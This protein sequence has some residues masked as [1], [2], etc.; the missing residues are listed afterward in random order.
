MS[1]PSSDALIRWVRKQ[2][3]WRRIFIFLLLLAIVWIPL[4]GPLYL[5]GY[6]FNRS[7][8]AE[9]LALVLLYGGFL[10]GLPR[11]GRRVHGWQRPF[12]RCGLVL[13][14]QTL[15]DCVIALAIGVA[16]VFA[17][18]G[19]ETL[20]GWATPTS[21]SPRLVRFI[22]EGLL[23]ALAVGFAEEMMFR[24]WILAELEET[25]HS[26]TAL[27]MN[28]LFFAGT[29]FIKP[30]SEVV[31][32]F[33]QFFGL[34]ALGVALVWA[35]RTETASALTSSR[36][37]SRTSSLAPASAIRTESNRFKERKGTTCLGYPIGLH[38]GLI[39]GYYIVNVGG[40]SEYTGRA[41]EWVT[42]IDDN[43]LAG[44]LGVILLELIGWQFFKTA[45]A[46][47]ARAKKVLTK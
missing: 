33:P 4:A 12:E 44:L 9:I 38:A 28:A 27:I 10:F 16:G 24:G 25:Y 36:A 45:R 43:P 14:S 41:P 11:W 47:T 7:G 15:K 40:L 2:G 20:L 22:F 13:R 39:W 29:H 6:A 37:S 30:W 17:L 23:M 32:T 21:P 18:F 31:R 46:K 42:G 3:A 34:V 5:L 26:T 1:L 19:I 35:R 8:T